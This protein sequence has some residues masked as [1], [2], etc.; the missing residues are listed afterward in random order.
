MARLR[1]WRDSSAV[2][3]GRTACALV[4]GMSFGQPIAMKAQLFSKPGTPAVQRP[5]PVLQPPAPGFS[6]P[7]HQ[8]LT[9]SVDWRVFTAGTAV[10]HLD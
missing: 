6:Y 10:Y 2:V 1:V 7:Q 3:L 9:Y 8:T 4:F 5:I